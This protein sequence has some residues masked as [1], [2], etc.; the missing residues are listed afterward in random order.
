MRAPKP[1]R[2][3]SGS[4]CLVHLDP[5]SHLLPAQEGWEGRGVAICIKEMFAFHTQAASAELS[6]ELWWLAVIFNY[7]RSHF[8]L[9]IAIW[10]HF[11]RHSAA[12][13]CPHAAPTWPRT[14]RRAPSAWAMNLSPK[15][16]TSAVSALG[17]WG[18][19]LCLT[20]WPS[21]EPLAPTG[22]N[23]R[24]PVARRRPVL[25]NSEK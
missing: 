25:A 3:A 16:R 14:R 20:R 9:T 5:R 23:C 21:R 13:S 10:H 15:T 22:E 12:T 4:A 2:T 17:S 1:C 19:S 11:N 8:I 7:L 18:N 24:P 6:A